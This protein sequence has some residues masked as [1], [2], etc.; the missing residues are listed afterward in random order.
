MLLVNRMGRKKNGSKYILNFWVTLLKKGLLLF[1]AALIAIGDGVLATTGFPLEQYRRTRKKIASLRNRRQKI[2]FVQKRN[3]RFL[4]AFSVPKLFPF[5]STA[6]LFAPRKQ[7][8]KKR[9]TIPVFL[10]PFSIKARYF[11]QGLLVSLVFIFVPLLLFVFVEAL[12]SPNELVLRQIPQTTKIYDRNRTL[13]YQIYAQQNRTLVPLS[14][15]PKSLVRATIA[16]EDKDFYSHPGFDLIAIARATVSNLSNE[17]GLQGG[18]TITQQLIKSALLNPEKTFLR[19]IKEVIIAFLAERIYTKDEILEMY[20]NQIPY[21]GTAWGVESAAHLYFGKGVKDLD[22]AQSALLAGLPGAPSLYSPFGED[23]QFWKK[24]QSAVLRK[25]AEVGYISEREMQEALT[26]EMILEREQTPL[27]A[28]HFVMY[29]RDLLIKKYGLPLVERGGL[30]VVTS[31]DFSLQEKAQKIVDEEVE[32][33]EFLNLSNGAALI[34]NPANGDILAMVGSR[35]FYD[36]DGGNVNVTT[37]LRQPGSSI[38]IITYAGAL[39]KGYTPATILDDTPIAFR[40]Q[41]GNNYSPVNYD[42]QFH[43]RVPMRLALANSFNIP[44]VRVLNSIGIPTMMNLARRMG[45]TTWNNPNRYGLSLTLGSAEV[46][47]TDMATVYATLANGGIRVDINPVLK[48]TDYKGSVLE[49][50]EKEEYG[51]RVLDEGVTFIISDILADN[52]SRSLEFGANSPLVIPNKRVS[53]KTGTSDNKRDNWTIGY[54]KAQLVAVWVGNN[55]NSP[56]SQ[57][58]ASGITGAA[59][60]WNKITSL[61]LANSPSENVVIPVNVVSKR[62]L[63]RVE[64]FI[65]GTENFVSCAPLAPSPTPAP[66]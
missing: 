28:P 6:R 59:P 49:E 56:M 30:S 32:K 10:V 36:P 8:A 35:N 54:T 17:G 14:D 22:L 43:G 15:I 45:I 51:Q 4:K 11:M 65:R 33:N 18:S 57:A 2:I 50:K 3:K 60:I 1:L 23:K 34:T 48:I 5:K 31:L 53:V 64:Y 12:P 40:D 19:K 25:M 66:M 27:K 16:I 26:E 42:G 29:V 38:K 9:K 62:C 7:K 24:R 58:L 52:K 55:D 37:S 21:G 44:A 47:M 63:G 20:F 61:V 39:S 41:W 46:R 13:L